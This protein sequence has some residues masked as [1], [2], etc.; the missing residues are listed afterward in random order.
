MDVGVTLMC[1]LPG[2][3]ECG[4]LICHQEKLQFIPRGNKLL[5]R[6][7]QA[8]FIAERTASVLCRVCNLHHLGPL[9]DL[10]ETFVDQ[11]TRLR[12]VSTVISGTTWRA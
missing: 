1:V 5:T 6:S 4:V 11:Y 8:H 9:E 7:V 3:T 12:L 2:E 10:D